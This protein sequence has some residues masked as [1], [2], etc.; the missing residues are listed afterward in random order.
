MASTG[1]YEQSRHPKVSGPESGQAGN[2]QAVT[3]G[4]VIAFFVFSVISPAYFNLG[5]LSLSFSR[6]L[7]LVLIVPLFF[8]LMMGKA[9]K[10]MAADY[11]FMGYAVW[12]MVSLVHHHGAERFAYAGIT[13][14]EHLGAYLLGRVLIRNIA[15]YRFLVRSFFYSLVILFPFALIELFTNRNLWS[16][17]FSAVFSVPYKPASAYGRMGLNRVMSGFEHPIL[18]G[19]YCSLGIGNFFYVYRTQ[20]ARA[21]PM[22]GFATGMTFMSLSSAPLLGATAQFGLIL[23]D[24]ITKGKWK[25]FVV[26]SAIAYVVIDLLSNRTPV[27]L[28]I[29]TLTYNPWS[30]YMRIHI[31]DFGFAAVLGSPIF[32]IGFNDWPRPFWLTSSVD[33]FWLV[34][35]MRHGL[36]GFAFL[37]GAIVLNFRAIIRAKGL[38]QEAAHYRTGYCLALAALIFALSTVHVWGATS[39]FVMFY[40]GAGVWFSTF[41]ATSGTVAAEPSPALPGSQ[42]G[43]PQRSS[44]GLVSSRPKRDPVPAVAPPPPQGLAAAPPVVARSLPRTRFKPVHRRPETPD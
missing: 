13:I 2:I 19:L 39:S 4:A 23:W 11:L 27:T 21:L 15:D 1:I 18:F 3:A 25:L 36:V 28:L 43:V 32:G 31:W 16:N 29:G 8:Q 12:V 6:L 14:I 37:A 34:V 10:V 5:G 44:S 35:M 38:S 17:A 41:A 42:R 9:G 22:M 26:L 33:N 20:L 7:L 24:Q 40:F 30:A